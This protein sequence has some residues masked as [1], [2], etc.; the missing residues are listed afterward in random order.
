[1][2]LYCGDW[3]ACNSYLML[4]VMEKDKGKQKYLLWA[5]KKPVLWQHILDDMYHAA[6]NLRL[7]SA[8][9]Q[10][11]DKE[12]RMRRNIIILFFYNILFVFVL[13]RG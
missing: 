6:L 8:Y 7:R 5:V 2:L 3:L 1:M 11:K 13:K 10:E 9:E 12:V 4:Q